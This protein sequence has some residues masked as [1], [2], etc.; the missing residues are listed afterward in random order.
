M[1]IVTCTQVLPYVPGDSVLSLLRSLASAF[2]PGDLLISTIRFYDPYADVQ[3]KWRYSN[4]VWENFA[5]SRLLSF[6]RLLPEDY[7]R[8]FA[9][10]GFRVVEAHRTGP[11]PADLQDMTKPRVHRSLKRIAEEDLITRQL[12]IIAR[13]EGEPRL[14]DLISI[15]PSNAN[16]S[17]E[18][19]S[20]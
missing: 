18:Y 11:S 19:D 6:N 17:S 2:H 20:K 14:K 4:F 13:A 10:A 1:K 16:S 15:T 3:H 9:L 7:L 12:K 5:C 8:I